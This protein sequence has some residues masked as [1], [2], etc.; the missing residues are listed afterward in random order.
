M[1]QRR[2]TR[3]Q[4][5]VQKLFILSEQHAEISFHPN[6][7]SS[8][9]S[10]LSNVLGRSGQ[11]LATSAVTVEAREAKEECW[12]QFREKVQRPSHRSYKKIE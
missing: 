12:E 10:Q 8:S 1:L 3:P 6:V 4:S 7:S 9:A 5:G 2:A 11:V